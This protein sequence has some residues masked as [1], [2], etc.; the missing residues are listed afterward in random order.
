MVMHEPKKRVDLEKFVANHSFDFDRV[1][2]TEAPNAEV[3]QS[4]LNPKP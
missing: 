2:G 1:F 3:I 4:I